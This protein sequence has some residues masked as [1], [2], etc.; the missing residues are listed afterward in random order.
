MS[1]PK[2]REEEFF[3]NALSDS[4]KKFPLRTAEAMPAK[5]KMCESLLQELR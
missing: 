2:Q 5:R 3:R 4:G 1:V